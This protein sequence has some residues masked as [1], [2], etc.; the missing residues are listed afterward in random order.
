MQIATDITDRKA[1]DDERRQQSQRL[2][3]TSRLIAMGEMASSLAH[4]LNQPLAAIANYSSGCVQRLESGQ[5]ERE[6]L[7]AAMQKASFQA[8]RAGKIIRRVRDFVR[9][10]EPNYAAVPLE[11]IVDDIA[12]FADIEARKSSV[13][14]R[15][16][17][18]P[19]LPPVYADGIM[20]EQVL[21]NLIKN[22][23]EA[24]QQTPHA[25]RVLRIDVR[26][27]GQG[28]AEFSV[29]DSGHGVSDDDKDKMFEPF[30][31]TKQEGMGMGLNICRTI[32][33]FHNGRLWVEANPDGGTI[34]RF[35]LP[36]DRA[37]AAPRQQ[38]AP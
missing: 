37:V 35:T 26:R 16:V 31:T 33:E 30:Y 4:E 10:S 8:E 29:A 13:R 23:I 7:L 27:N 34:F 24:M 25:R 12:G 5:F 17:V 6:E 11:Q 20:I 28:M 21:L 18:A 36:F 22:G 2:Q 19:D 1:V 38:T 3:Q 15:T 32:I 9:K 14:L